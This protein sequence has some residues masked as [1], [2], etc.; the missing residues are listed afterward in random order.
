MGIKSVAIN[1]EINAWIEPVDQ[2]QLKD[3]ISKLEFLSLLL[4]WKIQG[5]KERY[6]GK[7]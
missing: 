4:S 6:G 7:K 1:K 5:K 3:D 2:I